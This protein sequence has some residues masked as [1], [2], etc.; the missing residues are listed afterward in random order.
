MGTPDH[1]KGFKLRNT[2]V[3]V[4]TKS[5]VLNSKNTN[6]PPVDTA[7]GLTDYR[8]YGDVENI[9]DVYT[10]T[11][12]MILQEFQP[13][14]NAG[15]DYLKTYTTNL[16][17]EFTSQIQKLSTTAAD[18]AK[19][20]TTVVNDVV[21][22]DISVVDSA[23]NKIK[24]LKAKA[25][26]D[27]KDFLDQLMVG[28]YQGV[29]QIPY[30]GNDFFECN[31]SDGWQSKNLD[32]SDPTKSVSIDPESKSI[33]AKTTNFIRQAFNANTIVKDILNQSP[34]PGIPV[35]EYKNT[36]RRW[37]NTFRLYN[38]TDEDLKNNLGFLH[39]FISGTI[40]VMESRQMIQP[41]LYKLEVPGRFISEG[42]SMTVTVTYE[43]A[44]RAS[45]NISIHGVSFRNKLF[46]SVY[47]LDCRFIEVIPYTFNHY[48]RYVQD[49]NSNKSSIWGNYQATST[50]SIM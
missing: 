44:L 8:W 18:A 20:S 15:V 42:V 49:N 9:N 46:P 35:W 30:Y 19:R 24:K 45:D 4:S 28:T 12:T 50:R 38:K 14:T 7:F 33:A 25:F 32:V 36:F 40:P 10:G 27:D 2:N 6:S 13:I 17:V 3:N 16:L 29:F 5:G 47:V 34:I 39:S 41:N 21:G 23:V 1:R 31:A 11:P 48:E 22:T 43:G 37:S 26:T